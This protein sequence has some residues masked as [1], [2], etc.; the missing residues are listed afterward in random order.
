MCLGMVIQVLG[1]AEASANPTCNCYTRKQTKQGAQKTK[2]APTS[3]K[4]FDV[5][6]VGLGTRTPL[7]SAEIAVRALS[8]S[9]LAPSEHIPASGDL[10]SATMLSTT[11]GGTNES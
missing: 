4:N 2:E 7:R 8:S 9:P 10:D 11:C 6:L 3:P 5:L 1:S